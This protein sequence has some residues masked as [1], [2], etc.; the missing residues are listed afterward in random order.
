MGGSRSRRREFATEVGC[1]SDVGAAMLEELAEQGFVRSKEI[2]PETRVW[3]RPADFE[4][5]DTQ[6]QSLIDEVQEYAIFMLDP[7]G[8]IATWNKGAEKIKGYTAD[9]VI[10]EHF[11]KFYTEGDEEAGVP[12]HHL[13]I[14]VEK[15]RTEYEG[16]RVRKDSTRFW[17]NV[18]ITSLWND[19]GS[20]RGFTKVT[21]DMTERRE[22]K[23]RLQAERDLIEQALETVPV[24]ISVISSDGTFLRS[25]S[26]ITDRL[27]IDESELKQYTATSWDLYDVDGEP[28]PLEDDPFTRVIESGESVVDFHC[29]FRPESDDPRW[30]SINVSSIEDTEDEVGRVVYAIDDITEQKERTEQ[31]RRERNQ[32][33]RLLET[34]PVAISVQDA[35]GTIR[36]ANRRAQE[37]LGL[38]EHEMITE[39]ENADEWGLFDVAGDPLPPEESPAA[40]VHATGDPMHD[41]EIAIEKPN[42]ERLWLS[43]SAAPVYGPDGELERIISAGEDITELKQREHELERRRS[44]LETEL[45]EILG[46][47]SDAF[48]ALDDEWQFTHVNDRAEEILSE[49]ADEVLGK[50]FWDVFTDTGDTVL[51]EEFHAAMETQTPTTFEL[52]YERLGIW[53]EINAYPSETGLSVY[54]HDISKRKERERRLEQFASIVSHDLRNPLSIA[55]MYLTEA[56]INGLESDFEE[57]KRAHDRMERIIHNLLRM[58]QNT[59]PTIEPSSVSLPSVIDRAWHHVK[60]FDATLHIDEAM[61]V[62]LADE[63]QLQTVFENLFR[64]AVEH[65]GPETEIRVG[66]LSDGFFVEDDGPGIPFDE[67]SKVFDYGHTVNDGTGYGLT[68]V[69]ECIETH[70]WEID[71]VGS[72]SGG[73]RFEIRGVTEGSSSAG[74]Y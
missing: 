9:E 54:F 68:I 67:R 13:E 72:T 32:T 24:G 56:E 50:R 27:E 10:G 26:W 53:I 1:G 20:L 2:S 74:R 43:V 48:F 73:A 15:G 11:S 40:R 19:D 42:G 71:V 58:A 17:A 30:L 45:S 65:G 34:S 39:R 64:N 33:E 23:Q 29:Q 8:Y 12:E 52:N 60:T 44:E 57:V 49:S 31:L 25:N 61:P 18:V 3:W 63:D 62:V 21:R 7:D 46:R 16:Y 66:R 5:E 69:S 41:E 51:W 38:S 22:A 36:L 55:Q 47:V 35:D 37:V 70:G 4:Q 14:A 28:I 6:L 59:E